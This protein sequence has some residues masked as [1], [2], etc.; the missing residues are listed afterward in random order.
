[1][2]GEDVIFL[3]LSPDD[4]IISTLF[5]EQN[6]THLLILLCRRKMSVYS[7]VVKLPS[8][9]HCLNAKSCKAHII[10]SPFLNLFKIQ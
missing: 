4:Y 9:L 5:T 2:Y 10:T 3:G 8:Q 1:M 7:R 6:K